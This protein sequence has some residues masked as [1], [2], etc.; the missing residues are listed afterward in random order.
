MHVEIDDGRKGIFD[1]KPYL[2]HGV[3][4]ELRNAHYFKGALKNK[5]FR[6]K[7]RHTK[8]FTAGI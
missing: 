7:S 2:D 3:F 4:R 1:L 6:S 8:N 5:D